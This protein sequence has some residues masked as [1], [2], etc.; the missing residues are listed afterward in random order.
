MRILRYLR[1]KA[2]KSTFIVVCLT[3]TLVFFSLMISNIEKTYKS[4]LESNNELSYNSI[5]ISFADFVSQ[6]DIYKCINSFKSIKN[7]II[8]YEA[9]SS[10]DYML[11]SKGIYFNGDFNYSYNVLEGRFFT[12]E[13]MN[14]TENLAIIG[15]GILD[16]TTIENNQRYLKQGNEKYKIIGVIGKNNLSTRY[17]DLVLYNLNSILSRN[18]YVLGNTWYIDNLSL[19][20][21]I[22]IENVNSTINNNLIQVSEPNFFPNPIEFSIKSSRSLILGISFILICIFLTLIK[23]TV[24]WIESLELEIGIRKDY[25]ATNLNIFLD[26]ISRYLIISIVSLAFSLI[27]NKLLLIIKPF[28]IETI[29]PSTLNIILCF[30]LL[31]ALGIVIISI[32]MLKVIK[33]Q[34]TDLIKK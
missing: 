17:D 33:T 16:Y 29:G 4:I 9:P 22:I 24:F 7:S 2:R 23:S 26:I 8:F 11:S 21:N 31:I 3:S 10:F 14:S 27:I 5:S 12:K 1:K 18:E 25:G 32:A 20:K 19:N 15:K 28:N 6:L 13:D 34:I 30:I